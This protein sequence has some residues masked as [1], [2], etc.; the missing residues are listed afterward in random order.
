MG[1]LVT[2]AFQNKVRELV[3]ARLPSGV[4]L[5]SYIQRLKK[6]IVLI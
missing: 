6:Y 2:V 3:A 4:L 5:S 1:V